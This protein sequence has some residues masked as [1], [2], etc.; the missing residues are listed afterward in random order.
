MPLIVNH[1]FY[2]AFNL[3]PEAGMLSEHREVVRL[4]LKGNAQAAADALTQHLRAGQKRTLQRLKVLAV[5]PD[6]DLPA[7]M[8]RIA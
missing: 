4:L 7:Y 5:L 3:H 6:P 2:D 8:Q 1:A